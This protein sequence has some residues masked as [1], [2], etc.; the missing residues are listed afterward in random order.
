MANAFVDYQLDKWKPSFSMNQEKHYI[1]YLEKDIVKNT[2]RFENGF[3][4]SA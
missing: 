3:E 2:F 4:E 1:C